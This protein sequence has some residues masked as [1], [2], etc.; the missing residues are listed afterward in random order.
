MVVAQRSADKGMILAVTHELGVSSLRPFILG[1][2][3]GRELLAGVRH[4]LFQNVHS[5]RL[6]AHGPL[7]S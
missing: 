5:N 7:H 4:D 1:D 3:L 2:V 6:S